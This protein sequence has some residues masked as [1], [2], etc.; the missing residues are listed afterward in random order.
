[1]T[2]HMELTSTFRCA[3]GGCLRKQ[4]RK[5]AIGIHILYYTIKY[6]L[7]PPFMKAWFPSSPIFSKS[8]IRGE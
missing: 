8:K 5:G 1:M 6:S 2:K 4:G 7:S 3:W